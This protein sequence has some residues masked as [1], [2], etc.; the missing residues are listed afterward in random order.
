MKTSAD[1]L[2]GGNVMVIKV[3]VILEISVDRS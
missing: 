1:E 3:E 2:A